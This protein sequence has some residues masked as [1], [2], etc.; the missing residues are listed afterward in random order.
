MQRGQ[1]LTDLPYLVVIV[2]AGCEIGPPVFLY[3]RLTVFFSP[4]GSSFE[5]AAVSLHGRLHL[6]AIHVLSGVELAELHELLGGENG[7]SF[8]GDVLGR[9]NTVIAFGYARDPPLQ[10]IELFLDSM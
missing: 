1:S 6:S 2:V 10:V 4:N 3:A 9:G 7:L 5:I 8:V